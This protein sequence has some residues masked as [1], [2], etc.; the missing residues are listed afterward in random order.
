MKHA[1]I[2]VPFE[3]SNESAIDMLV[4]NLKIRMTIIQADDQDNDGVAT[5]DTPVTRAVRKSLQGNPRPVTS[6]KLDVHTLGAD[7]AVKVNGLLTL[8][9]ALLEDKTET[10]TEMRA[11]QVKTN[12]KKLAHKLIKLLRK[13]RGNEAVA[14]V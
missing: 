7:K 10:L 6:D 5:P 3:Y 1:D 8:T 4:Q 11:Y 12:L 14:L 9:R 2:I 13:T